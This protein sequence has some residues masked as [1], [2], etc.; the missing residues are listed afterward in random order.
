MIGCCKLLFL[1]PPGDGKYWDN[2][3]GWGSA[4][5]TIREALEWSSRQGSFSCPKVILF[6]TTHNF[7]EAKPVWS[8]SIRSSAWEAPMFTAASSTGTEGQIEMKQTPKNKTSAIRGKSVA[9]SDP[10]VRKQ[11]SELLSTKIFRCFS[12]YARCTGERAFG[13]F[14]GACDPEK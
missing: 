14:Y 12:G 9:S 1:S 7:N 2:F 8:A 5:D 10:I 6:N 11:K 13:C 4:F 3:R